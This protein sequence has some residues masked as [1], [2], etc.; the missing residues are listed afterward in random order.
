MYKILDIEGLCVVLFVRVQE[1]IKKKGQKRQ[2]KIEEV[3]VNT[4]HGVKRG[5]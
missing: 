1:E 3:V 2:K 5:T 4:R